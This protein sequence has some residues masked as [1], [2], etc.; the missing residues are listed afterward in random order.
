MRKTRKWNS[1]ISILLQTP[2]PSPI[3]H[4]QCSSHIEGWFF[5]VTFVW[6]NMYGKH[7]MRTNT[8]CRFLRVISGKV[9][10][11]SNGGQCTSCTLHCHVEKVVF[12]RCSFFHPCNMAKQNICICPE[13]ALKSSR[14]RTKTDRIQDTVSTHFNLT[15]QGSNVFLTHKE[16]ELKVQNWNWA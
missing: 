10:N 13:E 8:S 4:L 1:L 9:N 3:Y 6:R 15:L 2:E 14:K 16:Q 11:C 12:D 7:Y 5:L